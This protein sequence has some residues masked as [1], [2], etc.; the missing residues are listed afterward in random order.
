M[1]KNKLLQFGLTACVL[2]ASQIAVYPQSSNQ[3]AIRLFNQATSESDPEKKIALYKQAVEL[4]PT[5]IEAQY[6]IG[7]A[8]K[9]AKDYNNSEVYLNN[10]RRARQSG[11]D[12]KLLA[13]VLYHLAT[14]QKRLKKLKAAEATL[15]E[16]EGTGKDRKMQSKVAFELGLV[17]YE[18][19]RYDDALSHLRTSQSQYKESSSFF[20]NLIKIVETEVQVSELE[21]EIQRSIDAGNVLQAQAQLQQLRNLKP[22]HAG[23]AEKMTFIDS[24]M[25][26]KAKKEFLQ[27]MYEVAT[28]HFG[29]GEFEKAASSFEA[30]LQHDG[31]YRDA[32]ARLEEAQTRLA[33]Q[34][35]QQEIEESYAS[36]LEALDQENWTRAIIAFERVVELDPENQEAAR[37]L[38]T[39]NRGLESAGTE[40]IL[41]QYY[42]DGVNAM[43]NKNLSAALASFQKVY[44]INPRYK[45]AATLIEQIKRSHTPTTTAALSSDEYFNSLYDQATTAM[46]EK[47]WVQSVLTL[48]KL[49]LLAPNDH[50][51]LNL[52]IQ[53][54][55]NMK[56]G[57]ETEAASAQDGKRMNPMVYIGGFIAV[58]ILPVFGFVV[59][60]PTSRARIHYL[61]GNYPKAANIYERMLARHPER[62]KYYP[63]LANIYLIL[64]RNDERALKV[65]RMIIDLNLA[66]QIHPQINAVLSQK[67]LSDG[68]SHD[69][70]AITI[71]ENELKA[72]QENQAKS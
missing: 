67:Y 1:H 16:A 38:R 24:L 9:H 13:R 40:T 33:E 20:E 68:H 4:D 53:A 22:N 42:L 29:K 39:A 51:L 58:L 69:D 48:E 36:G 2:L 34:Q 21:A 49:R 15:H 60:S 32:K 66:K 71:L 54:K 8:Y 72:V 27:D 31:R 64:G 41:R 11:T 70:E 47:K 45:D 62:L 52:L 6:N 28:T 7:L 50:N 23:I 61:R 12:E 44:S 17:L 30:L 3:D 57:D 19:G 43:N 5:F 18:Q 55:E 35:K 63:T 56:L 25:N 37:K 26:D 10:A 46:S 59:F 65:F 14:V